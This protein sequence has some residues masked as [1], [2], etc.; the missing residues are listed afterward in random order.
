MIADI[1]AEQ[2]TE[3]T[4]FWILNRKSIP[5]PGDPIGHLF[6]HGFRGTMQLWDN[7]NERSLR[8]T[9]Q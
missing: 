4:D 7:L 6:G 3:R 1:I 2:K 5:F 8:D 9:P